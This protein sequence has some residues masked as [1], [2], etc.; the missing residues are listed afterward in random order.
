MME[1][2]SI[3]VHSKLLRPSSRL[4]PHDFRPASCQPQISCVWRR[5]HLWDFAAV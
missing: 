1:S 4:Y 3:A 5:T 2:E